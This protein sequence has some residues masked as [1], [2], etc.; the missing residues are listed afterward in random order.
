M[1][2]LGFAQIFEEEPSILVSN[3]DIGMRM[4]LERVYQR[5]KQVNAEALSKGRN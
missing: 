3:I 5:T 4:F 1:M 2:G